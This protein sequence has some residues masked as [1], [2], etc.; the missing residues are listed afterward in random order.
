M[1]KY[2][3]M[4]LWNLH[5]VYIVTCQFNTFLKFLFLPWPLLI[6]AHER[7]I[8]WLLFIGCFW[9][10]LRGSS[11]FDIRRSQA[12]SWIC[13]VSSCEWFANQR[14]THFLPRGCDSIGCRSIDVQL[15]NWETEKLGG[16]P[17]LRCWKYWR[18]SMG[19]HTL[20]TTGSIRAQEVGYGCKIV[21]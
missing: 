11:C 8:A 6:Y 17:V 13:L 21:V 16:L 15:G 9:L 19:Y 20:K 4:F 3:L 7:Y 14:S 5:A 10:Y 18:V 1:Y 12:T 2:A